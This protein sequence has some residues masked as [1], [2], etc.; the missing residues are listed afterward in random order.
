MTLAIIIVKL[1]FKDGLKLINV[2]MELRGF[3][4]W[5]ILGRVLEVSEADLNQIDASYNNGYDAVDS[6]KTEMIHTW[7][8][9][10]KN[11]TW[12]TLVA[13]LDAIGN[14]NLASKIA[15][16][17]IGKFSSKERKVFEFQPRFEPGSSDC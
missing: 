15:R 12:D 5:R 7:L 9:N 6:C 3:G 16:K 17:R 10:A 1:L 2:L 13:A 11:P 4:R 8:L 14:T